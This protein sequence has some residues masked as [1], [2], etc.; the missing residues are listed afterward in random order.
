MVYMMNRLNLGCYAVQY[1]I[2]ELHVAD[3]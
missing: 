3:L 1:S 2:H